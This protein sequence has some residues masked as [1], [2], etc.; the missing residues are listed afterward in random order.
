VSW[1]QWVAIAGSLDQWRA[2]LPTLPLTALSW[3]SHD[4]RSWFALV[5]WS[6]R[7]AKSGQLVEDHPTRCRRLRRERP[8]TAGGSPLGRWARFS[9]VPYYKELKEMNTNHERNTSLPTRR[10]L[11]LIY[12]L[13]SIIAILMAAASV[14]G[15]L[16]RAVIYPT[17]D[18]LQSFVSND[19][20]NLLIGLPILLGSMWSARRGKLIG[21]LLWPGALFFVL[22]N[23]MVYVF[24][25]P[26]N[27]AFLLHLTLVTLSAY[28]IIGLIASIDG[29]AVQQRLTGSVPERV[30]GGIL[31]GLGL[32]FFVRVIGV[33]VSALTSQTPIAETELALHVSDFLITPAWVIGGVLL[34]RRKEFGY[35]TG[36]GLLFQ[37]S[38]LFIGLIIFLLLQP[39]LTAAP[40][41]LADVVVI[42]ILGL[43]C[44]I[45][46][47]L[48]VRGVVSGRRSSPM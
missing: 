34:W 13:S 30:A 38:M 21:L 46:F 6:I 40:F 1:F 45:P 7:K 4:G 47:A 9:Q 2:R 37:A 14:T 28:T 23:Y 36:L 12:A 15:L 42:F 24:A 16:H 39:F 29:E 35:V 3:V 5:L 43:I 18:L 17:D 11:T 19:V 26:L 32:L 41:V 20:V 8:A 31:A 44:F 22:Y 25:M 33:I 27:V 10:N 48:F